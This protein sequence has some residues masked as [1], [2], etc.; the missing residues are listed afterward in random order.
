MT[1]LW[2]GTQCGDVDGISKQGGVE[3]V[4]FVVTSFLNGPLIILYYDTGEG[5]R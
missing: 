4:I 1:I 3:M 2:L 5:S